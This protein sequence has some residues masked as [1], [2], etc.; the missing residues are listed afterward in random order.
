MSGHFSAENI[1]HGSPGHA[2]RD[3]PSQQPERFVFDEE[4]EAAIAPILA[5]YPEGRQAS[6]VIPLLYLVQKQMRRQTGSAWVPRVGMDAVAARLSMPPIRVYEVATFYLM[7][8]TKPVGRHHLQIC[9]TTPCWLRGSDAVVAACRAAT[10]IRGWEETS[11]DGLFTMTEV[12]CLGACA[13][14]P[15]MQINDDYYE[16]LDGPRTTLLLEALQRGELPKPGS[17]IG[18]CA[19]A[20]IGERTTLLS[21][22]DRT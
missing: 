22:P 17:S 3:V 5:H 11:A 21:P 15:M 2:P 19:S 18:R 13:N 16:D 8:N 10:G 20:P 7:F 4:S 9:T 12:E 1:G 14:A 6:G